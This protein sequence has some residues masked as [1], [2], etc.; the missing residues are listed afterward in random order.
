MSDILTPQDLLA[1]NQ[2]WRQRRVEADPEF[3]QRLANQQAPQYLWIGCSDSRVPASELIDLPPGEVFVHRNVANQVI[4]TDFNCLSVIQ[5]AVDVLQVKHV[6][7]TGHYHCGGVIA[8]LERR[9]LGLID[10]WLR[11]IED[12]MVKH[13]VELDALP[14]QDARVRRL[15][16]LNVL[17]QVQSVARTTFVQRAWREGQS[18]QIHGWI[19]DVADGVLQDL[20]VSVSSI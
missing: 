20:Q 18:L 11:H 5:Y 16:E 10:N 17:E 9:S 6:I 2:Q 15:C 7:V 8:T 1:R 4:H 19:Y 3:F 14:N 12:V 13:Q